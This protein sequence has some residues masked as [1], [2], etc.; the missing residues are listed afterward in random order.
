MSESERFNY[1]M[2]LKLQEG[3]KGQAKRNAR[4]ARPNLEDKLDQHIA[5][6]K[7]IGRY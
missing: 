7:R 1:E 3:S 2:I 4:Q 5:N 6:E